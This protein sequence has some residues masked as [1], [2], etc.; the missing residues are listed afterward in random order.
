MLT[1]Q[2]G[3]RFDDPGTRTGD[4]TFHRIHDAS[5]NGRATPLRYSPPVQRSSPAGASPPNPF[6]LAMIRTGEILFD[7]RDPLR[8]EFDFVA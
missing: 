5:G 6:L 4:G 7:C 2:G 3:R 8:A 1:S